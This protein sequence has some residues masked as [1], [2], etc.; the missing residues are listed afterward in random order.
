MNKSVMNTITV[1]LEDVDQN[2]VNFNGAAFT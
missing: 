1:Y 2:E